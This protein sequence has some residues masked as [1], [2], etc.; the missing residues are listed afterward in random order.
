MIAVGL[1]ELAPAAPPG[2]TKAYADF[3][4]IDPGD[5][6]PAGSAYGSIAI[7]PDG[8]VMGASRLQ[9]LRSRLLRIVGAHEWGRVKKAATDTDL[10][11]I[12][13]DL[14]RTFRADP[15]VGEARVS[16]GRAP[17]Y[18]RVVVTSCAVRARDGSS[19]SFESPV[20]GS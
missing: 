3:L 15:D 6:V 20:G 18:P 17:G 4:T 2:A 14:E 5:A 12:R 13:S 11:R 10:A 9:A 16:A 1:L 19:I 7:G 8:D